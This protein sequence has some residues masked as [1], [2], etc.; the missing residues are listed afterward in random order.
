MPLLEGTKLDPVVS[1]NV[2]LKPDTN[3]IRV[4]IRQVIASAIGVASLYGI[5]LAPAGAVPPNEPADTMTGIFQVT[6]S[7]SAYTLDTHPSSDP[8][9]DA[10]LA[11]QRPMHLATDSSL[12]PVVGVGKNDPGPGG[13][14]T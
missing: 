10:P 8:V 2:R 3:T 7:G 5:S 1:L 9:Y 14:I 6:G 13:R 4:R 11:W 12:L